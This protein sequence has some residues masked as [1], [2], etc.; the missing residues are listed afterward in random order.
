LLGFSVDAKGVIPETRAIVRG[1]A[2]GKTNGAALVIG[3]AC[4][5]VILGFKRWRPRI[6]GVLV[7][8]VGATVAVGVFGLAERYGLSV[9]GPLSKGLPSFEIPNISASHV[10]ALVAGAGGVALIS[11][12]APPVL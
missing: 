4:L 8:V 3:V 12:A 10:Q 2:D 5:A 7:A 9:V 6:P 1:V 11:F